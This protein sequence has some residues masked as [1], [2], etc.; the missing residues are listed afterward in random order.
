M[1]TTRQLNSLL[2]L[3]K[4]VSYI[5]HTS[6]NHQRTPLLPVSHTH[7]NT[8][9]TMH[10]RLLLQRSPGHPDYRGWGGGGRITREYGPQ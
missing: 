5:I 9:L 1:Q 2:S 3:R 6:C 4:L 8:P 7:S 10:A